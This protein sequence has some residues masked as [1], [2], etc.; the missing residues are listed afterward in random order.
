MIG[1]CTWGWDATP[2]Y[3]GEAVRK[4]HQLYRPQEMERTEGGV[5]R[6][7]LSIRTRPTAP[8]I[9]VSLSPTASANASRLSL[10]SF[11]KS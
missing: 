8:T 6:G 9:R 5:S 3:V 2:I 1:Y 7:G 11:W 4:S 10:F